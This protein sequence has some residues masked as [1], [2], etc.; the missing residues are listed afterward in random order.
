MLGRVSE[1]VVGG[2]GELVVW[3]EWT[4]RVNGLRWVVFGGGNV[5]RRD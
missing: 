2:R 1:A 3:G 5:T 4:G